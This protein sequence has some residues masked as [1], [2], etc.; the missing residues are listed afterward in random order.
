MTRRAALL[1]LLLLFWS[2]TD[3]HANDTLFLSGFDAPGLTPVA[4]GLLE[5]A[6]AEIGMRIEVVLTEPSRALVNSSSGATDGEVVRIGLVG[7]RYPALV[8]V[9]V[10]LLS[11]VTYGYTTRPEL[12]NL[13]LPDLELLRAG[14]VRGAVFGETAARGFAE[15]WAADEPEQ[16]FE[17]LKQGRLDLVFVREVRAREMIA[18][19]EL[20]DAYPIPAS[21]KTYPFYHYLHERHRALVPRV[22][23]ALRKV[24]STGGGHVGEEP[25]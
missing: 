15:V 5:K 23:N 4:Q 18:R 17:M 21:R 20:E 8:R 2:G 11:V 12:R 1:C 24:M 3:L 25:S 10:P 6:Y 19:F 14:H 13:S 22:E 16:L 7:D 9:D